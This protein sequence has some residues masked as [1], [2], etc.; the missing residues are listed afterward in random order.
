MSNVQPSQLAP[1]G[2]GDVEDGAVAGVLLRDPGRLRGRGASDDH[3]ATGG[4]HPGSF[5]G[6]K[7]LF[8]LFLQGSNPGIYLIFLSSCAKARNLSAPLG[9]NVDNSR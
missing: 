9:Y 6:S 4:R 5:Q 2:P 8:I 3:R 1:A 7:T